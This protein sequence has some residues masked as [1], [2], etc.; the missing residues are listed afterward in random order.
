MAIRHLLNQTVGIKNPTTTRDKYGKIGLGAG[1]T[2]RA[3]VQLTKKTI[4]TAEREREPIDMI[5]FLEPSTTINIGAQMTYGSTL[6]RVIA[7][8]P[9]PGRNG[10]TNHFEVMAQ[11]W[12]YAS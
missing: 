11:L 1:V 5:A 3:R 10:E 8:S 2:Y 9:V 7:I 6:Y 4:I 12:S